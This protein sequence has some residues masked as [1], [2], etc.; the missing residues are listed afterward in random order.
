M[1]CVSWNM[2]DLQDEKRCGT[3]GRYLLEWGAMVVSLQETI[4]ECCEVQDWNAIGGGFLDGF[5]TVKAVGGSG[6]V[7]AAWNEAMISKVDT[8][9]GQFSAAAKLKQKMDN[10]EFV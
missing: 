10:L 5:I 2:C 7:V 8:L 6:V 4:W 9:K 3:M 1:K